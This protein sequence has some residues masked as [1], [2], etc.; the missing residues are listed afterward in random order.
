M[1]SPSTDFHVGNR[2]AFEVGERKEDGASEG[3]SESDDE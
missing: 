2:L 1:V 3:G